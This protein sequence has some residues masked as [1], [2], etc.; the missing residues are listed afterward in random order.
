MLKNIRNT[1]IILGL[2]FTSLAIAEQK[3]PIDE[4]VGGETWGHSV[5]EIGDGLYVFR[6]W[7]YRNIFIV[8]LAEPSAQGA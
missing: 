4:P 2:L 6:W 7:V 3:F 5:S 8:N 1:F